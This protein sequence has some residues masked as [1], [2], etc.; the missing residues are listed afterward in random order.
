MGDFR[1]VIECAHAI[2]VVSSVVVVFISS[3]SI[4]VGKK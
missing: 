1:F 3:R 2:T 4:S